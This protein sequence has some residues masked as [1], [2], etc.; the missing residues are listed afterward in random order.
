MY[1]EKLIEYML[2]FFKENGFSETD[3]AF[4]CEDKQVKI[5]YNEAKKVYELYLNENLVSA[6]LF[7][8]TQTEKDTESVAIDFIDTLKSKLGIKKA[9]PTSNQVA[10]PDELKGEKVGVGGLAQKLLA[11]FPAHKENYKNFVAEKGKY[12]PVSFAKEYFI[13]SIKDLLDANSKKQVKKFYDAMSD[14][15]TAADG[16]TSA[17]VVAILAAA[18]YGKPEQLATLKEQTASCESLYTFV[19]NFTAEM[20]NSKKLR[21]SLLK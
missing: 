10:L 18:V 19:L 21:N 1:Y 17:L 6:Y 9:K 8:E 5:V 7:D 3:G 11:I 16:E 4:V 13:P 2:P 12:L 20:K 15:F 14:V